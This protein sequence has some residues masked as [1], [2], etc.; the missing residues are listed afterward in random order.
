MIK[1]QQFFNSPGEPDWKSSL[2]VLSN[3]LG[4]HVGLVEKKDDRVDWFYKHQNG[5]SASEYHHILK[6]IEPHLTLSSQQEWFKVKS[7]PIASHC[8]V[9]RLKAI[10]CNHIF[11]CIH[12]YGSVPHESYKQT[13][14][15]QTIKILE[16]DLN[17]NNEE[18]SQKPISS[19]CKSNEPINDYNTSAGIQ[20]ALEER[21]AHLLTLFNSTPDFICFKDGE[22]RWM[23]ANQSLISLFGLEGYDYRGKNYRDLSLLIPN[24]SKELKFCHET[25]NLAWKSRRPINVEE[26]FVQADG[27]RKF[28]DVIKAPLFNVDGSRKGLVVLGRDITGRKLAEQE[29]LENEMRFKLVAMHTNDVIFEWNSTDDDFIWNGNIRSIIGSSN[30]PSSFRRLLTMIHPDDRLKML[31]LWRIK[32]GQQS[33][34]WK[35]EFRLLLSDGNLIYL[36]GSGMVERKENSD[37]IRAYGTI[38]NITREK[39]LV[40]TLREALDVAESNHAKLR[41]LLAIIPDI[42]FVFNG[43]GYFIDYHVH[44]EKGLLVS[45]AS[46]MDK[47]VSEVLPAEL[48]SLT[49]ENINKAITGKG[50]ETY[51][52][53]IREEEKEMVYESRMIYFQANET[54]CIVRDVTHQKQIEKELLLAKEK[55]EESDR[56]KSAFLANMSHE[57]RTPMNGIMGFAELLKQRDV[58]EDKREYYLDIIIKSGLQLLGLI[59]DVLEISRIETGSTVLN[60]EQIDLAELMSSL[61]AFFEVPANDKNIVLKATLPPKKEIVIKGD[62]PKLTQVFNNLIAN[63]I[64]FTPE[65]G[66]IEFGYHLNENIVEFFVEDSGIGIDPKH[67]QSIFNRFNQVYEKSGKDYGGAGLGLSICKSLVELM[68]G[69]IRVASFPKKGSR[70]T[71]EIPL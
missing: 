49:I 33:N 21:N 57:I 63:A 22:G 13:L 23:E 46:F 39:E 60:K 20:E 34:I 1:N 18:F 12:T 36:L 62:L 31:D 67:H 37:Q 7:S 16:D 32:P 29:N 44:E 47:H 19:Y 8:F 30:S 3:V 70:F 50:V 26:H 64:K 28:F 52:Y 51:N 71:F 54:I 27:V 6:E 5:R 10:N 11:L 45:P 24:R 55:A 25:D 58:S 69:E 42:I 59:N 68:G 4:A 38:T 65:N 9:S 40:H 17:L 14:I 53:T 35:N 2:N 48:A 56:L 43:D 41:G 61:T 66:T 15:R